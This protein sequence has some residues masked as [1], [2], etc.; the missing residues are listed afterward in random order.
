MYHRISL[1]NVLLLVSCSYPCLLYKHK[2]NDSRHEK[3]SQVEVEPE[4]SPSRPRDLTADY[5]RKMTS[6]RDA[7]VVVLEISRDT[8]RAGYGLA[9]LMPRPSV[10]SRFLR[11][12]RLTR[13][14]RIRSACHCP[15]RVAKR[16]DGAVQG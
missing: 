15:R 6:F 1:H 9:E 8:I 2:H 12:P 10:V 7:T 16:R 14:T 3:C 11:I 13:F 5:T 4:D